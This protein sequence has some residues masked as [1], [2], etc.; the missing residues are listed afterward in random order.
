MPQRSE[1][2]CKTLNDLSLCRWG[3]ESGFLSMIGSPIPHRQVKRF[4]LRL[5]M[6]GLRRRLD[7]KLFENA[8]SLMLAM[9]TQVLAI[10]V[11]LA[12]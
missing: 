11:V 6:P 4:A 5:A 7:V 10:G 1:T 2:L 12:L 8:T 9:A 3:R